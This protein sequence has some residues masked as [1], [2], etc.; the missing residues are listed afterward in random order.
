MTRTY[1]TRS[2]AVP[3]A[4]TPDDL[5]L[6]VTD[7]ERDD[8]HPAQPRRRSYSDVVA[9]RVPSEEENSDKEN[10]NNQLPLDEEINA[11]RNARTELSREQTDTVRTAEDSMTQAERD[12]LAKQRQNVRDEARAHEPLADP[13]D[14]PSRDKGKGVDPRNWGNIHFSDEEET[15]PDVQEKAYN[16]WKAR[17][18]NYLDINHRPVLP[19][20]PTKPVPTPSTAEALNLE[21]LR[22]LKAIRAE[23]AHLR[24]QQ[25]DKAAK[26]HAWVTSRQADPVSISRGM[27]SMASKGAPARDEHAHLRPSKQLPADSYLGRAFRHQPTKSH[28]NDDPD[29]LSDGSYDP[30]DPQSSSSEEPSDSESSS[31]NY[32]SRCRATKKKQYQDS[33]KRSCLI[34]PTPPEPYDGSADSQTFYRFM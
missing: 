13:W 33:K 23:N 34:K 17:Q 9:K 19:V 22:E 5:E 11:I 12:L 2:R 31:D 21:I 20:M 6:T 7:S 16:E 25:S 28:P 18:R 32:R 14:G 29:P 26:K 24:E 10:I 8:V 3:R 4:A 30:D 15:R 27:A 1:A